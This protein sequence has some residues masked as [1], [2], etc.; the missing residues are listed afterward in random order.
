MT[1]LFKVPSLQVSGRVF[2]QKHEPTLSHKQ[3]LV[4]QY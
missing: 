3:G 4:L 2:A 1:S